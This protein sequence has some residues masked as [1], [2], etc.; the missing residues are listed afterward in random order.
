MEFLSILKVL[1]KKSW[2]GRVVKT[3]IIL[4]WR[5]KLLEEAQRL[6]SLTYLTFPYLKLGLG[7]HPLWTTCGSSPGS[8][9]AATVMGKMLSGRYRDDYL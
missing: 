8:V 5:K 3:S 2:F 4:Y 6:P 7:P 9:R 1:P